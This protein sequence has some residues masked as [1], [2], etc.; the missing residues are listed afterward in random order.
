MRQLRESAG[1]P[2]VDQLAVAEQHHALRSLRQSLVVGDHD[3]RLAL[4]SKIVENIK[5]GI[6]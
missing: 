1:D 5:N 4:F 2:A 6:R 3:D